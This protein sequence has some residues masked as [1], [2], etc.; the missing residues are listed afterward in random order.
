VSKDDPYSIRTSSAS[1]KDIRRKASEV[2]S[3]AATTSERKPCA[4]PHVY[5]R[6][7]FPIKG[8]IIFWI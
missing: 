2:G 7:I 4:A 3:S 5:H 1:E 6:K 8:K